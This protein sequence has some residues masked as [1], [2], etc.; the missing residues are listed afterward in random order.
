MNAS[1][2]AEQRQDQLN[3]ERY[4]AL[5][6]ELSLKNE[7][8]PFPG[9]VEESYSELKVVDEEYPGFTT[10]TDQII[11][12]MKVEG[13]KVVLGEHPES[14]N[15][16]VLPFLSVDIEN[17]SLS[18]HHLKIIDEMDDSLKELILLKRASHNKT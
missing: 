7:K 12:R 4:I 11:A 16:F 9:L 10:P 3:L 6:K 2:E 13:I 15:V 5:A 1:L 18:P 14:G 17:D 8:L